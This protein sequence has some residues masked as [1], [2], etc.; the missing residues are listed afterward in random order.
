MK[1]NNNITYTEN[2]GVTRKTTESKVLDMFAVGGAYRTRSDADI[3]LIFKNAFEEDRN[4]AMKCLFY[5]RDIRG[6]QGERRFFR[7]A[8]RWLCNEYPKIATKN[9]INV[10]EYGR[11]DD[12]IYVSEGTPVQTAA[13]NIIKHQLALDIQCQ[14]PSLLAK[15]LPSQNAS[16]AKTK[17]LGCIL[18]KFLHMSSREYRKTLSTLRE[19]INVLERLMSA[20]EWDKIEFDKIPSKAGLIYRNAFARRDILAKKYEEFAK[21]KETK[22]NAEI[23]YPYDIAHKAFRSGHLSLDNPERLMLQKYWDGLKDFYNGRQ[24]NGLAIVDVSGSMVGTPM[25][26]AVSMGAYIADKAHGPFANHFITFSSV[27]ELVEFEGVDIVDKMN[28]C[29]KADWGMNTNLKAVFNMLLRIAISQQ[30]SSQDM[31]ERLYI[32]SDME[33]DNCI[34]FDDYYHRNW[35]DEYT[36]ESV[37]E[38]N[39]DLE[40]IKKQWK[41]YGYKLPQVIFWNLN[42]R[43]NRIPAIGEGFSYVSGFSPSMIECILG[44]KDGYDLMLEKLLSDRYKAVTA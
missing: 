1:K 35:C 17:Q 6:G 44:G 33:F 10:S 43:Q 40:K 7:V 25:E 9:L 15:W 37:E 38:I 20:G 16:S 18:A 11:W 12:L 36:L 39:S 28:R 2:G 42:A 30:I 29:I 5:L 31:P 34:T 19:R 24:E 27:P 4:L 26:A 13:F 3:I 21:N 8:F 32:F 14:T 23:L 22:V 41:V